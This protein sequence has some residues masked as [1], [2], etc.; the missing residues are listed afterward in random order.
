MNPP[1]APVPLGTGAPVGLVVNVAPPAAQPPTLP[2]NHSFLPQSVPEQQVSMEMENNGMHEGD[3]AKK[4]VGKKK[5][6]VVRNSWS[7][8]ELERLRKY[9]KKYQD[10]KGFISWVKVA[11]KF[12]N[13]TC[14]SAQRRWQRLVLEESK[15]NQ[16]Q[17]V[18][19]LVG[20][21]S[22]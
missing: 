21:W 4:A 2:G 11:E 17:Y 6:G 3:E 10:E 13:R 14:K 18:F 1:Q 20:S 15:A 19:D 5:S 16:P 7:G 8:E 12:T 9:T 22:S